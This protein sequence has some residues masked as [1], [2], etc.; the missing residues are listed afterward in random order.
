MEAVSGE[1]LTFCATAPS[2]SVAITRQRVLCSRSVI[3]FA[4]NVPKRD[5]LPVLIAM[6]VSPILPLRHVAAASVHV[7]SLSHVGAPP[8]QRFTF[9]VTGLLFFCLIPIKA[10]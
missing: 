1:D 6:L 4:A 3:S 2:E 10:S 9:R 7:L 5:Y 8:Y